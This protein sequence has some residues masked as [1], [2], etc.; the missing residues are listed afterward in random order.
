MEPLQ[1]LLDDPLRALR[2]I[3]FMGRLRFRFAPKLH[4]AM[5]NSS[6][7]MHLAEKVSRER[8]GIELHKMFFDEHSDAEECARAIVQYKFY[9]PICLRLP[10]VSPPDLDKCAQQALDTMALA[11]K[12]AWANVSDDASTDSHCTGISRSRTSRSTF[13]RDDCSCSRRSCRRSPT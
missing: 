8:V 7:R 2:A 6:T 3:R 4:E 11:A 13:P 1:T 5:L 10:A 9:S 12:Y